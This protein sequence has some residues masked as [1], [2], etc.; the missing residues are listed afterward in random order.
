MSPPAVSEPLLAPSTAARN[1]RV[2]RFVVLCRQVGFRV[3][4]GRPDARCPDRSVVLQANAPVL[5]QA[6]VLP[7]VCEA[8]RPPRRWFPAGPCDAEG[9]AV[10]VLETGVP[11]RLSEVRVGIV[12]LPPSVWRRPRHTRARG[13]G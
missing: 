5:E 12:G 13:G 3:G 7:R 4:G 10:L 1:V 9:R 6:R 8:D 11:L 2:Q